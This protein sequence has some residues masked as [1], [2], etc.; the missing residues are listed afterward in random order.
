M[1]GAPRTVALFGRFKLLPRGDIV[2]LLHQTGAREVK[3]LTRDTS[4]LAIGSGA[5]NL[6]GSALPGRLEQAAAR[7]I[8][9]VGEARLLEMLRDQPQATATLDA[10]SIAPIPTDL[11]ALL[12]AF[13]IIRMD[14]GKLR[15]EDADKLRTAAGL[16]EDGADD[17]QIIS[18]LLLRRNAPKGRHRLKLDRSG[19]PVLIWEDGLTT[20]AGQGLLPLEDGKD[21]ETLFDDALEAEAEGDYARAAQLYEICATHDARDPIAP[22]NLGNVYLHQQKYAAGKLAYQ[23]AIARRPG[24]AE[25]YFNLAIC[26]EAQHNVSGAIAS[27]KRA[28]QHDPDYGEA[29]FNLAQIELGQQNYSEAGRLFQTFLGVVD[30]TSALAKKA[31]QALRI[32][33]NER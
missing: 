17:A 7:G 24:F 9:V 4:L 2:R 32:I 19:A 20:L 18:A 3:D 21:L 14:D 10:S 26:E 5:A 22:F 15:F 27:L 1:L 16:V 25:A 8:P 29:M 12:N 6:I 28:L 23:R 33:E 30:N 11:I 13:D 31:N